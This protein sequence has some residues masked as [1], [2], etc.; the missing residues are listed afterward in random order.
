MA[1]P[2]KVTPL[3]TRRNK[4]VF[5]TLKSALQD[6]EHDGIHG[7]YIVAELDGEVRTYSGGRFE[8]PKF[9]YCLEVAKFE[10]LAMA[11][12]ES[13]ADNLEK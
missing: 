6:A 2:K 13:I 3:T 4:N 12:G 10:L 5:E 1:R 11:V 9:V 8:R 7:I